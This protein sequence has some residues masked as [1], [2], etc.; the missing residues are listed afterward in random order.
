MCPARGIR[1]PYRTAAAGAWRGAG[2]RGGG[3]RRTTPGPGMCRHSR[4][5]AAG[6]YLGRNTVAG[7]RDR[8]LNGVARDTAVR[9]W[10]RHATSTDG[11]W[12][13]V[14]RR[15]SIGGRYR[16]GAAARSFAPKGFIDRHSRV[17]RRRSTR[18]SDDRPTDR[19]QHA[20]TAV[21]ARI[22]TGSEPVATPGRPAVSPVEA[23]Y[24][25]A[26]GSIKSRRHFTNSGRYSGGRRSASR[27]STSMS[28]GMTAF[29]NSA[30]ASARNSS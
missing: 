27:R 13:T 28:R 23:C 10:H 4:L 30:P 21:E 1:S 29:S 25:A 19:P 11:P 22:R 2:R 14:L 20:R 26:A 15:L 17:V 3:S 6:P 5:R 18:S 12:R 7:D 24:F 16:P 8:A 9:R